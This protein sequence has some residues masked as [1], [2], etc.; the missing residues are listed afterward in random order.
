[1]KFVDIC[2][3]IGS[4]HHSFAKHGMTCALACDIEPTARATYETNHGVT[5]VGDLYDVDIPNIPS[6]DIL[7]AGFPCQPFSNAGQHRGF[8]DT[9]GTVF[10]QIMKWVDHHK[11]KYIVFENVP[12]IIGHDNGNTFRTICESMRDA[13]YDVAYKVVR[14]SDY[15]IPQMRKRVLLVGVRGGNAESLLDFARF[16]RHTTLAEYLQKPFEKETAYTIRCGGR[17]SALG[18]KHNWDAYVVDGTEYRLTIQDGLRLQGF[19]ENFKLCGSVTKQW[20]QLGNTIPTIFTEMLAQNILR[21]E[22]PR[23]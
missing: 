13:G 11:P 20:K 1:M 7:C 18:N 17:G 10:F 16:E 6:F 12:A 19:P 15:G 4:F 14:C 23:E 8:E 21:T 9:R 2:C 3:G 22:E 5:A